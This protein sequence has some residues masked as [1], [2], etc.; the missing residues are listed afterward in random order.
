M[1]RRVVESRESVALVLASLAGTHATRTYPGRAPA[2]KWLQILQRG[3]YTG[4]TILGAVAT[5]K[6]SA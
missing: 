4:I 1:P 3:L 5:T 6:T 2:P